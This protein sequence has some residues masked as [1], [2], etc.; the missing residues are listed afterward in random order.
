MVKHI[1]NLPTDCVNLPTDCLIVFDRFMWLT[2]KGLRLIIN[3]L[4]SSTFCWTPYLINNIFIFLI[5]VYVYAFW[6]IHLLLS[7][8]LL[9]RA[10]C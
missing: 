7:Y 9:Y 10:Y 8:I 1:V 3:F 2:L 4:K 6:L 5:Y